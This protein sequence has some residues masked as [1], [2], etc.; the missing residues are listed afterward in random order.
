MIATR[1][2]QAG[3]SVSF[4]SGTIA[5]GGSVYVTAV[6]PGSPRLAWVGLYSPADANVSAATP[7]RFQMLVADEGYSASGFARFPF[8]L[9]NLHSGGFRALLIVGGL[10]NPASVTGKPLGQ[11]TTAGGG[12]KPWTSVV[13]AASPGTVIAVSQ[14][15]VVFDSP[16]LPTHVRVTFTKRDGHYTFVWNQEEGSSGGFLVWALSSSAALAGGAGATRVAAVASRVTTSD[17]CSGGPAATTGFRSMGTQWAA[18]VALPPA[19]VVYYVLGDASA[20]LAAPSAFNVPSAPG[21]AGPTSLMLYADQAVGASDD[22]FAGR[23]YNNGRGALAVAQ[24][25]AAHAAS[26]PGT[27]PSPLGTRVSAIVVSGDASYADGYLAQWEDYF[28][29]MAPAAAAVPLLF[30][31]GNHEQAWLRGVGS[32][33]GA[34]PISD[35]W[36]TAADPANSISSGGECGLAFKLLPSGSSTPA[37]PWY[38]FAVGLVTVV[39]WSSEHNVSAGSPQHRWLEATLAAVDRSVTPWVLSTAHRSM[40]VD[41]A[42]A[43]TAWG[44]DL[45][46]QS[47]L[48]AAVEPLFAR[49]S[50]DVHFSGH[51][52]VTQ[53]H[54]AAAAGACVANATVAA[55]GAALYSAPGATVYYS[56]GSAGANVDTGRSGAPFTL[57]AAPATSPF[58]YGLLTINSS[59]VLEMRII[60]PLSGAVIDFSRITRAPGAGASA[61][62]ASGAQV[63]AVA[64]VVLAV[65]LVGVRWFTCTPQKGVTLLP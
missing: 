48:R 27:A 47:Y 10:A 15:D 58:G 20:S 35:F 4:D 29:M 26:A 39:V 61:A 30:S 12:A 46:V 5:N 22:A 43:S 45:G 8:R 65:S 52:H 53:R 13:G 16:N 59:A 55:D 31:S 56:F 63:A 3:A 62:A 33:D 18:T 50:V 28:E 60:D 36:S 57:W 49:Y 2:L 34:A 7:V 42:S 51:T 38:S 41:S 37:A 25:A 21:A 40:Y 54:C 14:A 17:V 23:A 1:A 32:P 9:N 64:A 24:R 19:A 44:S 6:A 11:A